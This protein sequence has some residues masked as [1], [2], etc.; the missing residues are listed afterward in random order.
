MRELLG[1]SPTR[2]QQRQQQQ[3]RHRWHTGRKR[4]EEIKEY[5]P[6]EKRRTGRMELKKEKK[7]FCCFSFPIPVWSIPQAEHQ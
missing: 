6:T 1:S 7:A 2:E 5:T 4:T 3:C